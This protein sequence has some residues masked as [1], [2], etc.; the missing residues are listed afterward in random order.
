MSTGG[1]CSDSVCIRISSMSLSANDYKTTNSCVL[2]EA[3]MKL[4]DWRP[5]SINCVWIYK[6]NS[7]TNTQMLD[8]LLTTVPWRSSQMPLSYGFINKILN[9]SKHIYLHLSITMYKP[10]WRQRVLSQF[11]SSEIGTVVAGRAYIVLNGGALVNFVDIHPLRWSLYSWSSASL[12][13]SENSLHGWL[14]LIWHNFVKFS[15]TCGLQNHLTL[16]NH[17]LVTSNWHV[18]YVITSQ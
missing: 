12:V 15:L 14:R 1:T 10:L 18:I 9:E 13:K 17:L 7:I 11:P 6:H 8:G 5:K 2:W 16:G 4:N 3:D